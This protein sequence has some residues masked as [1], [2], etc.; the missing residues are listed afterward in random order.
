MKKL[1]ITVLLL[2]IANVSLLATAQDPRK[3]RK[4]AEV[5]YSAHPNT[6]WTWQFAGEDVS[7]DK[8]WGARILERYFVGDPIP[9]RLFIGAGSEDKSLTRLDIS[10]IPKCLSIEIYEMKPD[11]ENKYSPGNKPIWRLPLGFLKIDENDP[12]NK[13]QETKTTFWGHESQSRGLMTESFDLLAMTGK[14]LEPGSYFIK[15]VSDEENCTYYVRMISGRRWIR[16][17]NTDTPQLLA[18]KMSMEG[19]SMVGLVRSPDITIFLKAVEEKFLLALKLDPTNTC[20]LE[21]MA[22]YYSIIGDREKYVD[23]KRRACSS[24]KNKQLRER[25][26]QYLEEN[27][28][29]LE[30]PNE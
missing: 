26:E 2:S 27:R 4:E 12:H 16:V 5:I 23:F 1:L 10:L 29:Q 25:C 21:W 28:R 9:G 22:N 3:E 20:A 17:F 13:V 11:D 19:R 8:P 15:I 30:K 7:V 24:M 6:Y 18:M 14:R